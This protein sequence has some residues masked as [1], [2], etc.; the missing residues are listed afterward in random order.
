MGAEFAL[1]VVEEGGGRRSP[2]KEEG[3]RLGKGSSVG[4]REAYLLGDKKDFSTDDD[5]ASLCSHKSRH[6]RSLSGQE[7]VDYRNRSQQKKGVQVEASR[8]SENLVS[9]KGEHFLNEQI[10]VGQVAC[11]SQCSDGRREEI[12][13]FLCLEG[14]A[15]GARTTSRQVGGEPLGHALEESGEC[16]LCGVHFV[17]LKDLQEGEG[18]VH[19]ECGGGWNWSGWVSGSGMGGGPK[20]AGY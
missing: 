10:E 15:G 2:R 16:G 14:A 3:R 5:V 7:R 4:S 6:L 12:D 8:G 13:R 1:W 20:L 19:V 11:G 18:V 17:D 9:L